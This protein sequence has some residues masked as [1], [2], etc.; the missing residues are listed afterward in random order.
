MS[1][2]YT[3][4]DEWLNEIENYSTRW[5]RMVGDRDTEKWVKEAWKQATRTSRIQEV[6][7]LAEIKK[8]KSDLTEL[9]DKIED[10]TMENKEEYPD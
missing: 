6:L 2:V 8:L 1:K 4:C 7:L 5:E 10:W 9:E 3:D